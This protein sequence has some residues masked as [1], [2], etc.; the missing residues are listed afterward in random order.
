MRVVPLENEA[1]NECWIA[2]RDRFSY[3]AVNRDD[4]LTTPMVKQGGQWRSVDWNTALDVVARGLRQIVD[5]HGASAIGALGSAHATVEELHLLARL[6]RG[7][8]SENIDHRLRHSDFGNRGAAGTARWLGMPI[9]AL[10]QLSSVLLVGSFLRKDHPL[11]AQRIRQAARRGAVVASL[12]A[13]HDDW[14]LTVTTRITAA[15]SAWVE[16]LAG[17]AAAIGPGAPVAGVVTAEAQAVAEALESGEHKA[18]LLGNTAAQ[19]PQAGT[20]LALAQWIGARTGAAVGCFGEAANSVGAQLVGAMPGPGGL[21]AGAMLAGGALQ[22][23]LLLDVEPALDAANPA[24]AAAALGA[25]QMVVALTPFR[26][27]GESVADVMLPIT[28]FTETSGT[29]VNAEGRVQGFHGVVKPQGESRP[30]WK[31]L[32]VLG[33]LLGVAG[34]DFETSEDVRKQALGDEAAIA[35]RLSNAAAVT[36]AAASAGG[37]ERVADVPIYCT[38]PLVRRAPALQATADA[39]APVVGLSAATW[40]R[41][42]L[43]EGPARVRVSQGSASVVLPAR[44]DAA[45]ATHAV[46]VAAGHP[47]TSGLG[48]MFG[49]IAVEKA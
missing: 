36:A 18:V 10:S 32:R 20:L 25:A 2:D 23:A 12:N 40:E 19:H 45:L 33:N 27:A 13:T 1:V 46:R 16:A 26:S 17:I 30:A 6:A 34:F 39:A 5:E 11:F 15:P 3:E 37:L 8:G 35:S 31:V 47:S 44:L 43:G 42:G 24:A 22:A 49:P 21:D 29:F 14:A 9:T 4:R 48:A 41:L 7:L 28:P 38:D